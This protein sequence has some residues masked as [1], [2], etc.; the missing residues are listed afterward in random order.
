MAKIQGS[1]PITGFVAPT[2]S[3]DTY[4]SHSEEWGRGGYRTVDTIADR[5]NIS[6]QRQK[7]GMLVNVLQN[8]TIYKLVNGVWIEFDGGGGGATGEVIIKS[9]SSMELA[10]FS[11]TILFECVEDSTIKLPDPVLCYNND[12]SLRININR[13]D[14]TKFKLIILP[15]LDEMVLYENEFELYSKEIIN[16]ITDGV[17]WHLGA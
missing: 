15:F 6:P 2:D 4:P 14:N 13:I 16:L 3:Q 5:E 10:P 11:K 8:N 12:T 7:E 9:S 1:V 17:N